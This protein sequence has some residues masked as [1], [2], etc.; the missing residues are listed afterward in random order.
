MAKFYSQGSFLICDK[1]QH[2]EE[3]LTRF[4]P[5]DPGIS[6]AWLMVRL[7]TNMT[8]TTTKL[9]EEPFYI[10]V[11]ESMLPSQCSSDEMMSALMDHAKEYGDTSGKWMMFGE[12]GP[13]LT[14]TWK[15]VARLCAAGKLGNG[16]KISAQPSKQM[17]ICVYVEDFTDLVKVEEVLVTLKENGF[18]IRCGFK[19]DFLTTLGSYSN[20]TVHELMRTCH[21]SQ[22]VAVAVKNLPTTIYKDMLSRN[23]TRPVPLPS[24]SLYSS[25]SSSSSSVSY[26]PLLLSLTSLTTPPPPPSSFSPSL[27]SPSSFP[28]APAPAPAPAPPTASS[29]SSSSS[30][31]SFL[32]E[33]DEDTKK[34]KKKR[35]TRHPFD[36]SDSE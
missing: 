7:E 31:S 5:G 30:S 21:Y 34:R 27:S 16:C 9:Y 12:V 4:I 11:I 3:F 6:A 10:A 22:A 25:S 18:K 36:S 29:S 35:R 1:L 24:S 2:V 14:E 32:V 23:A 13:V 15:K 26:S 20:I 8:R 17:L 28:Q 33:I 19:P